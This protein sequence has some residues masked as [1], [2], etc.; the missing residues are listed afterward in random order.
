MPVHFKILRSLNHV[1]ASKILWD[2]SGRNKLL[3]ELRKSKHVMKSLMLAIANLLQFYVIYC[4]AYAL[5]MPLAEI[6]L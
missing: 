2:F 3:H 1:Y 6:I 4:F 5:V